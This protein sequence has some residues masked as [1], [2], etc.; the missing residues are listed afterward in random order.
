MVLSS[1]KFI[2][3]TL[4]GFVLSFVDK[5]APLGSNIDELQDMVKAKNLKNTVEDFRKKETL[6]GDNIFHKGVQSYAGDSKRVK[7]IQKL[8]S[9][10]QAASFEIFMTALRPFLR[11]GALKSS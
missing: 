11:E 9:I 6:S 4:G 5:H 8:V 7:D 3:E 10:C 2:A 1:I